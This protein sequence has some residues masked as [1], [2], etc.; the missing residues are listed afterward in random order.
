MAEV[1]RLAME[2]ARTDVTVLITGESGTGKELL[3]RAIHYASPRARGPLVALN[4]A[5]IPEDLLESE[6]FGYEKGAF[7]DAKKSKRGRFQL[8][9]RG[10]LFLDEIGE[11]SLQAQ[12][13]LLRVL[14]DRTVD[15]LGGVRGVRVDIRIIGATNQDLAELI[16]RGR[17]REDLYY[18]FHVAPLQ[19]PPLRRRPDDIKPLM[20]AFLETAARERGSRIRSVSPEALAT[21]RGYHWPGNVRELQR[22]MEGAIATTDSH[23]IDLDDL[24]VSLRGVYGEVLMPALQANDTMRAWGSRYARLV[25]ERCQQNK[26]QACRVLG[27]TYHTLRAYLHYPAGPDAPHRL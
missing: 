27:I 22:M 26:R 13:K 20:E 8:A 19:I 16:K 24:P 25:L 9:D 21:L 14:E 3:A 2:V 12:A 17:F 6:L 10:T 18:R 11:M 5:G 7:T 15:P 1:K 23:E 4:C